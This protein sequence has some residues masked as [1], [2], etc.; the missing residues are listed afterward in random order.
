MSDRP[1][2]RPTEKS[3]G[4]TSESMTALSDLL[5]GNEDRVGPIRERVDTNWSVVSHLPPPLV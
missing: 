2:T 3:G 5:R 4:W 1:S